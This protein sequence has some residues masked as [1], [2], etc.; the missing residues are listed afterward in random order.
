MNPL[1]ELKIY[2]GINE[3][4]RTAEEVVD[5][6]R[7]RIFNTECDKRFNNWKFATNKDG[8]M[9]C[10]KSEGNED[11]VPFLLKNSG[12]WTYAD[13]S[14]VFNVFKGQEWTEILP[15]ARREARI[16]FMCS[17]CLGEVTSEVG[18]PVDIAGVNVWDVVVCPVCGEK[19]RVVGW[20]NP[21]GKPAIIGCNDCPFMKFRG[22]KLN[23]MKR[24]CNH[25]ANHGAEIGTLDVF[26]S[27]CP[28]KKTEVK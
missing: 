5:I 15:K 19:Q 24:I 27:N 28:I 11:W 10:C 17:G 12:V 7:E 23:D 4:A 9:I 1:N 21:E 16:T 18:A 22:E 6:L 2:R 20:K 8:G 14:V 13:I 25:P 3:Q 26:G